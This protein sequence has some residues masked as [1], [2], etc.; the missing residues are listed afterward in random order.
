MNIFNWKFCTCILCNF[1]NCILGCPILIIS[2]QLISTDFGTSATFRAVVE[3]YGDIALE[4][5]WLRQHSN[6]TETLGI[7]H[8]KYLG[9]KDL[10]SP[11]LVINNVTFNDEV[12][13]QLQ[14]RILGGWCFGNT[15]ELDVRG[16][17]TRLNSNMHCSIITR[18]I[19]LFY[20]DFMRIVH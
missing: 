10:P 12:S 5:R 9:S 6:K 1:S 3:S 8:P 13:Y 7:T 2:P 4:S 19:Y 15:V 16:S 18:H 17:K 11:E 20:S 14:V